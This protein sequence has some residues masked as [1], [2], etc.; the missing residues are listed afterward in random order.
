MNSF[1]DAREFS[2]RLATT[3]SPYAMYSEHTYCGSISYYTKKLKSRNVEKKPPAI[4]R[5]AGGVLVSFVQKALLE[6]RLKERRLGIKDYLFEIETGVTI[7]G[8]RIRD[9]G[10][11]Q[12]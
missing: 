5:F 7:P 3:G 11:T 6:L 1:E 2:L 8:L 12:R 10:T 9:D 4:Q